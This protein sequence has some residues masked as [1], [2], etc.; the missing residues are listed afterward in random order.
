MV[1]CY[2]LFQNSPYNLGLLQGQ[3]QQSSL[4]T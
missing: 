1:S 3:T 4:S 2:Q